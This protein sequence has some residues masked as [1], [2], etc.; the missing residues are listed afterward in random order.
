LLIVHGSSDRTVGSFL[1][2]QI[3][4][5]L[6]RL[7]KE[8]EYV[9]YEGEDHSPDYWSY[10]NQVDLDERMIRWFDTHLKQ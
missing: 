8:A 1:A 7:N 4:V 6:R 2:D 10:A 9:K 3:F 5:S